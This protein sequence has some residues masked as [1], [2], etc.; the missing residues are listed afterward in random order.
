MIK[1]WLAS[2]GIKFVTA[3]IALGVG[4]WYLSSSIDGASLSYTSVNAFLQQIGIQNHDIA[5]ANACFLCKYITELFDIIGRGAE[6]FWDGIIN[7][8]WVLMAVGFGIF[9]IVHTVKFFH[10][11]ASSKEIKDLSGKDI[12][13]DFSKWF[14]KVWKNGIRVFIIGA[15]IGALGW[16]GTGALKTVTN[17]T[18]TPVMYIGSMLSMATTDVVSNTQCNVDLI[19]ASNNVLTPVL[20]PFMCIMGNL[21]TV[22]LAGAG[23]GFALMNYS[24]LGLGGGLFTWLA[25]LALVLTFLIIG[26]DLLFQVLNVIV[27]LMFIIIF[28]PFLLAAYAFENIWKFSKDSLINGAI[29]ML[30][31]SAISIIRISLK[32]CIIYAMVYFSADTFYPGPTDGFTTIMPPLLGKITIKNPDTET[33]SVIN[34]FSECEKV[35]LVDNHM[36]KDK[37][38]KCFDTQKTVVTKKYPH[39][40]DFMDDGFEFLLFMIGIALLYFWIISP[41]IDELINTKN[42]EP[43][44]YGDWLKQ[45]GKTVYGA[46][47]KIYNTIK[48]K[49]KTK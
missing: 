37:F 45:F 5:T 33:M 1:K 34:V 28:M 16:T 47:E 36:D 41:K 21:N 12:S 8:L 39:A 6:M 7:K 46:P 30:V 4:V 13:I 48:E 18:V 9:I 2:F 49:N 11:Q 25:G 19:H 29:D 23:G 20:K 35:A 40:F 42:K 22:M 10:E 31:N 26:F 43:F 38:L 17:L 44:N 27:K 15:L 32:I 3:A 24:W 14:E